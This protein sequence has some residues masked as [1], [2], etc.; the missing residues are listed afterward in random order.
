MRNFSAEIRW[1]GQSISGLSAVTPLRGTT[2]VIAFH[3]GGGAVARHAPGRSDTDTITLSRGVSDDLAFDLWARGPVLRKTVELS[4]V[5]TSDGLTV[6]YRIPDCWVCGYSVA[7]DLDTGEVV[8]SLSLSTGQWHRVSPP[9][10]DLAEHLAGERGVTVHRIDVGTLLGQVRE[11]TIAAIDAELADAEQ[12]GAVLLLDEADALFTK[13]SEVQDSHDRYANI[14]VTFLLQ[15][16]SAYRGQVVV[17]PP[18]RRVDSND[19]T[20]PPD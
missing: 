15:R 7:P 11:G 2:D 5:D 16:L 18:S 20:R 1:D 4:L 10:P 3:E 12:S 14:D 9:A 6:T 13:R 8:E 17:A 19:P